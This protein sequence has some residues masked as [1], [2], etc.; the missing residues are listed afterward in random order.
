MPLNMPTALN[1][2][3]ALIAALDQLCSQGVVSNAPEHVRFQGYYS[4]LFG[5]QANWQCVANA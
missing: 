5:A 3:A 2:K 4:N 1:K